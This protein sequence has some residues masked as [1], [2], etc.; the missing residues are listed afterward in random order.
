[1]SRNRNRRPTQQAAGAKSVQTSDSFQNLL[2]RTGLGAGSQNDG[3]RYSFT[4]VSRDR[5]QLEFCYRSSW[6]AGAVV[7][8]YAEDMTREGIDIVGDADPDKIEQLTRRI[9]SLEIMDSLCSIIKWSRLYGGA[10]GVLMID[11]Q[12]F[13]TP[14]RKDTISKDQFKGILVLDR[15]V[16]TPTLENLVKDFGPDYGKPKFYDVVADAHTVQALRIHHSRVI[17]LDGVELP[18]WQRI[19]ENGW[20]QSVLERLWDRLIPFDSVTQGAAQLA[21]KAHLRTYKIKGLREIIA[22][23]GKAFEGLTAQINMIRQYQSNE[24]LTLMDAEDEF[25]AHAYSFSGLSDLIL[26]FGQQISGAT[27]IPLVR[28]FGQSPAGLNSTGESDIRTYYD[29]IKKDQQKRLHSGMQLVLD[30]AYRSEFGEEPPEGFGFKFRPLWQLSDAEKSDIAVK[31]TTA[32]TGA[33]DSGL[34]GKPTALKE[35]RQSSQVTGVFTNI[36]DEDIEDAENEP[37]MLPEGM[38]DDPDIGPEA[39]NESRE[40]KPNRPDKGED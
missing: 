8:S 4:P 3:S 17:R 1:M 5:V 7:D 22:A 16:L 40:E 31:V 14:L 35:L 11:G 32:V 27:G 23:G 19:A 6:I 34:I 29:N 18:Y 10:V 36:T 33:M 15:W 13:A 2:T 37:P 26:Q 25:E 9:T 30:V 20:G 21:Y 38:N 12:D 39:G 24:G 28:L